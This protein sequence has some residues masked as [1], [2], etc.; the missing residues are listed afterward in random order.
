MKTP[1]RSRKTKPVWQSVAAASAPDDRVN[2]ANAEY[3][4]RIMLL[5]LGVD[6]DGVL[7]RDIHTDSPVMIG[8]PPTVNDDE[9]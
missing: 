3:G 6:S 5:T 8:T 1:K 2:V 4:K 7:W 9:G